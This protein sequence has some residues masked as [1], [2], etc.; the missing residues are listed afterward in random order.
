MMSMGDI[1]STAGVFSTLRDIMSTQGHCH[2]Y[3]EGR[4]RCM[5]GLP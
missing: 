1:M 2:E 3:T 4:P 5:W